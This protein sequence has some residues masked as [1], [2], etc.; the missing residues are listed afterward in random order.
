M[1]VVPSNPTLLKA[2]SIPLGIIVQPMADYFTEEESI[3]TVEV[4]AAGPFRCSKCGG[5]I[6][7]G[8][9]FAE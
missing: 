2:T 3:P 5:Y 7:P 1:N 4:E 8:F 9:N 6:N